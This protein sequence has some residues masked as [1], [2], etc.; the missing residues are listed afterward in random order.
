M[1]KYLIRFPGNQTTAAEGMEAG[2]A[3]MDGKGGCDK[4]KGR[5]QPLFV[6]LLSFFEGQGLWYL[7][8]FRRALLFWCSEDLH[9]CSE[10]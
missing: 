8:A 4:R 7:W 10:N 2:L 5:A 9:L 3:E 6:S 1:N